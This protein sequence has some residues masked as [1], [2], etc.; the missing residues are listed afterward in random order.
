M[1]SMT[2]ASIPA[3]TKRS[4]MLSAGAK[5]MA[6]APPSLMRAIEAVT[7]RPPAKTMWETRRPRHTSMSAASSGCMVMR[8]TPNGWS[9]R[10]RVAAISASSW[11]GDMAPVAMTPKPPPL[12][13]AATRSWFD[14]HV[15]APPM[16]A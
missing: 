12:E 6:L 14:T 3:R 11:S 7:C 10:S 15:M 16:M 4:E 2:K 13:M 9:V 8:F 1:P 5:A